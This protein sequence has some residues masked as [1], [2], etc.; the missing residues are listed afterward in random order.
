M[1][2]YITNKLH[3]YFIQQKRRKKGSKIMPIDERGMNSDFINYFSLEEYVDR[4]KLLPSLLEHIEYT[5]KEFDS[6]MQQLARYD[7]NYI[8]NYWIYLLYEE[9]RS[10]Q[11]IE[12]SKFN[13]T[14]VV[15]KDSAPRRSSAH[16]DLPGQFLQ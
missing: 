9:L 8:V 6:Y 16:R 2:L 13:E 11:G 7:E 14:R 4:I 3:C 1:L 15:G 10:S 12:L 5:N